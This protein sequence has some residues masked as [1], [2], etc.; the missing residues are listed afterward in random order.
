[1]PGPAWPSAWERTSTRG[2]SHEHRHP[3]SACRGRSA[4]LSSR[5]GPHDPDRRPQA[6]GQDP[7][8]HRDGRDGGHRPRRRPRRIAASTRWLGTDESAPPA[9]PSVTDDARRVAG[10]FLQAYGSYDADRATS[11]L[12]D[13]A[14]T[15]ELAVPRRAPRATQ[16]E[17]GGRLDRAQEPLP[18]DGRRRRHRRPEVRLPGAR[19][20]V[21]PAGPRALRRDYWTLHVL[22]GKIVYARPQ[23]PFGSNG[24]S[25]EMW[26]PFA[27]FVDTSYP[28]DADIMYTDG[29]TDRPADHT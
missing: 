4:R 19:A 14:I 18:T 16:L 5:G 15:N 3:R 26:E 28:R 23:F 25:A 12:A 6:R 10:A 9:S 8:A 13:D 11:Y 7:T 2:R 21:R 27:A 22:D 24:F 1:M 29:G 20:R 17:R